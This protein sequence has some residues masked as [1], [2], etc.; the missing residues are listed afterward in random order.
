MRF[1]HHT[2]TTHRAKVVTRMFAQL[3]ASFALGLSAAHAAGVQASGS[4]TGGLI[5]KAADRARRRRPCWT[6]TPAGCARCSSRTAA[7]FRP[8][9]S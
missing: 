3:L 9:W 2:I 5:G 8:T 4:E 6:T 7:K 1:D